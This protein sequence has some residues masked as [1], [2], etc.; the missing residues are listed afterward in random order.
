MMHGQPA[1]SR[2]ATYPWKMPG[3]WWTKNSRYFLY[4]IRELTAVFAA[5][6]VVWFLIQV[7][8]M[9]SPQKHAAWLASVKSPGWLLF[10]LVSLLFVLYH[11]WTWIKLMGTVMYMRMGKNVAT[12][13][14][15][16]STM[17]IL[18]AIASL[19]IAVIVATP[20]LG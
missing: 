1:T 8:D 17:L 19:L 2:T 5:L 15:V 6:W 18:W 9:G 11:A 14:A 4:M 16:S 3:D 20:A 10:S 12:G 13:S 7:P